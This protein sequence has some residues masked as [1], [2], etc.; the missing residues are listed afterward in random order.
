MH[1]VNFMSLRSRVEATDHRKCEV[2][3]PL[4][5]CRNVHDSSFKIECHKRKP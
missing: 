1:P 2:T 3:P 5:P 4:S